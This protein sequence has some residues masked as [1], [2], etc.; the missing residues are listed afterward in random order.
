M[1]RY[2]S[3][4]AYADNTSGMRSVPY[5][6]AKG[7]TGSSESGT[8]QP[9]A[10][11]VKPEKV[12]NPYGSTAGAG[13]GEFHVYR[14]ARSREM[15]RMAQ[16]TE[17]E[18]E[19]RKDREFEDELRS[20]QTEEERRTAR[21]RRKRQREKEAKLR[22][23]TLAKI[24]ISTSSC[25]AVDQIEKS[26]YEEESTYTRVPDTATAEKKTESIPNDGSFLER[27]KTQLAAQ[28]VAEEKSEADD[29]EE[30]SE[31]RAEK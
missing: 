23:K 4:Q 30:E 26:S 10:S 7:T 6:Q 11:I 24:G 2:S 14:H 12:V 25:G 18:E 22:K 3:V 31:P 13:S 19:A 21:K 1:G 28:Q 16:L 17:A 15:Q 8:A 9:K 5:E 27:M 20:Y 29:Q